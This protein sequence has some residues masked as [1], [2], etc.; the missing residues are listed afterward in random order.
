[1][2]F[3]TAAYSWI[4]MGIAIAVAITFLDSHQKKKKN[5]IK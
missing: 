4:G 5:D 3:F 2:E 1:M